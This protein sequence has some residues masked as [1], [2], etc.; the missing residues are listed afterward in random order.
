MN[1]QLS[2]VGPI[3]AVIFDMDGLLLDTEGIYTE[4]T[5][6]IADRY[7]RTFD[8]TIKQNIIG[9]GAADLARYVVEALDL[10]ITAEEFLVIRE[11]LMRERFPR[12]LAMPGA[13]ELVQHLKANQVPIAVGTSS[14]RQSF[15]Q[16]TTRHGDWFALFDTIVTAD[17]PEVG[18]AKPAPDIFLTA[19]RRLGVAPEDCLVFEDSPFGVTAAKAAGMTAIAIPDP[20]MAD[21]KYAHADAIL[22]SLKGFQPAACGLPLLQWS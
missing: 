6:I 4:V 5:Q 12:A 10:P 20:A 19:A 2:D 13:Q 1:A 3:K 17:D 8:W 16:K 21:A 14:S 22:R 9:R 7:G 18:A 15:A 11:P